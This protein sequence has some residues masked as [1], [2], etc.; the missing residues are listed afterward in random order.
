[1]TE[2]ILTLDASQGLLVLVAWVVVA[3][4]TAAILVKRRDA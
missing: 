4:V 2:G 3:A 1:V